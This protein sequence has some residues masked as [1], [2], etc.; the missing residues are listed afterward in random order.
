VRAENAS[1]DQR[2]AMT[3]SRYGLTEAP[4]REGG[5]PMQFAA[6]SASSGWSVNCLFCHGGKLLGKPIPGLPNSHIAM[7]TFYDEVT[8]TKHLLGK[9]V[10]EVPEKLRVPLGGSNGT[11]N[12]IVFGVLL[13]SQRDM[14]LNYQ[15]N[16][17]VPKLIH[18]DHDAPAWWYIKKKTHLYSDGHS[19]K[20]HRALMAFMMDPANGPQQFRDAEADYRII[21]AWLESLEPPRWPWPIDQALADRGREVF[22]NRCSEC[23]GQ[24]GDNASY[25]N[26]IVPIEEVGTDRARLDSIS[27]A[28]RFGAQLTWFGYFGKK[29][30]VVNPGGYVAPPLDGIWASAPYLHNGSVPTLRDLFYPQR[31]PIVWQRSEDGYDQHNIGIEVTRYDELPP[32]VTDPRAKRAY[33]DTRLFAKSNAGHLFPAELDEDEK[34][35]VLEYLK[36]L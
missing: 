24:Y 13:G 19:P 17:P 15:P 36:T 25:P 8:Q 31:R 20:E 6:S 18:N 27:P 35:A 32:G 1:S 11:T 5:V 29:R 2:R 10:A 26:R 30:M 3:L 23:H 28:M 7:Q 9:E 34:Q 22:N 21:L 12:A 4:G 16:Q 14:F 33:F